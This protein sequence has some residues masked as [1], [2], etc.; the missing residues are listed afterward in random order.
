M[1]GTE[2]SGDQAR[3]LGDWTECLSVSGQEQQRR[4]KRSCTESGLSGSIVPYVLTGSTYVHFYPSASKCLLLPFIIPQAPDAAFPSQPA[5]NESTSR[6]A[7][8]S[9]RASNACVFPSH[10]AHTA[11]VFDFSLFCSPIDHS[12]KAP[13]QEQEGG[14]NKIMHEGSLL[15]F[16]ASY[17]LPLHSLSLSPPCLK[18]K[19]NQNSLTRTFCT[20]ICRYFQKQSVTLV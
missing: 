5:Q 13:N 1:W 15:L 7:P 17:F 8:L 9:H 11:P 3:L 16:S 4:N 2:G 19:K 12:L 14:M 10:S 20:A 6:C 18:S